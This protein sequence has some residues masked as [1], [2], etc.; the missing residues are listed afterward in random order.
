LAHV[1][2]ISIQPPARG[3][4]NIIKLELIFFSIFNKTF[5]FI[6]VYSKWN[7]LWSTW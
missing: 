6:L 7:V 1:W 2:I 5:S 3:Y 4:I